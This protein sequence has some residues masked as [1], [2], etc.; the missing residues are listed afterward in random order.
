MFGV[1]KIKTLAT[2]AYCR[3]K[4]GESTQKML[5]VSLLLAIWLVTTGGIFLSGSPVRGE[6]S[7]PATVIVKCG[8]TLWG[9][10]K[11]HAPRGMDLRRYLDEVLQ[12]NNLPDVLIY[13]GQEI[14]LP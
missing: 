4:K 6:I 12:E 1:I 10:A 7:D 13:P 3:K 5:R 2:F 9:L 11:I 14:I 8:D